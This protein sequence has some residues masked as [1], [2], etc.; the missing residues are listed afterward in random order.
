MP[1]LGWSDPV[2]AELALQFKKL[3]EEMLSMD[4]I[5]FHRSVKPARVGLLDGAKPAFGAVIYDVY[6]AKSTAL[7]SVIQHTVSLLTAKAKVGPFGKGFSAPRAELCGS[8]VL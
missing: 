5:Y 3:F 1:N 8:L 6:K 4:I 2:H 7:D